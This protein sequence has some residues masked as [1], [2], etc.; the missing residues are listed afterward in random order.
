MT[1]RFGPI[2]RLNYSRL[3]RADEVGSSVRLEHERRLEPGRELR[4]FATAAKGAGAIVSFVGLVRQEGQGGAV[5]ALVLE[6]HPVLTEQSI[7][8]IA[9]EALMRFDIEHVHIV[10]LCGAF[11]PGE[12]IVFAAAAAA[13]RRTAF[14]AANYVM[15]RLKTDAVFWKR[16]EGASERRWIEPTAADYADRERWDG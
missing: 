4:D 15:D 7:N 2:S 9:G 14:E 12:P 10:H 11:A 6:H 3:C 13:H 1:R 5:E 16:E 8:E